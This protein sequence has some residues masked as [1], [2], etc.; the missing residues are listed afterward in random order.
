MAAV[1][2]LILTVASAHVF[3]AMAATPCD[4]PAQW[5]GHASRYDYDASEHIML[6]MSYDATNKR[7]HVREEINAVR[8][9]R[10]FHEI[11]AIYSKNVVYTLNLASMT[12]TKTTPTA[13]FRLIGIPSNAT[14][15]GD[16]FIGA[17]SNKL[18][19]QEWSD[20]I[21]VPTQPETWI[22]TFTVPDCIPV[23]EVLRGN[24]V[25]HAVVTSFY[26]I[27]AGIRN[28]SIFDPPP[29]CTGA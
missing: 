28:A 3:V 26:D 11:W 18:E 17:G 5:E 21:L 27:T 23:K 14:F 6:N 4:S 13:P 19:V 1:F 22:G 29:Q 7:M 2:A 16:F 8:P 20:R 9:G 10:E 25:D 12:C 15:E 24:D